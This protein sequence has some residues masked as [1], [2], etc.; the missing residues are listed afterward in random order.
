MQ[1]VGH[2]FEKAAQAVAWVPDPS[3][4]RGLI[5][6]SVEQEESRRLLRFSLAERQQAEEITRKPVPLPAQLYIE[7]LPDRAW[8]WRTSPGSSRPNA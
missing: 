1:I 7:M 3:T 5:L 6:S 4:V 2:R 8:W